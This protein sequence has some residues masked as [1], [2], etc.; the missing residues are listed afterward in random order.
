MEL[1]SFEG[2]ETIIS[3]VAEVACD[4]RNARNEATS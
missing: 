3:T 4:E 1:G 2:E